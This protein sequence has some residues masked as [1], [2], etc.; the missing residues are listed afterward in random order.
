MARKSPRTAKEIIDQAIEENKWN[1]RLL[2]FIAVACVVSGIT[3][4][5]FGLI[6]EQGVVAIAGG[7]ASALFI[8]AMH[9]ARQIRRENMA[10]RLLEG[11][12]G[13]AET[14]KEASDALKEF[15]LDTFVSRKSNPNP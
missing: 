5:I 13:K 1:E 3:A 12:L 8:P 2:Y 15:F 9:Q 14:A 10:I 4:L 6:Q 11:P 7:I